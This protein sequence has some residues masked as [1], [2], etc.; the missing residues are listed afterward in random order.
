MP[1]AETLGAAGLASGWML[2]W[3]AAGIIPIAIHLLTRRRGQIVHWGA[4]EL[5]RQVIEREAKR[6]RIEQL[7]LLLLRVA[8]LIMLALAL[9]R[10]FLFSSELGDNNLEDSKPRFWIIALDTSY[11]MSY[12]EAGRTRFDIAKDKALDMVEKAAEGDA[13][14]LFE[15]AEPCRPVIARP[16]FDKQNVLAEIRRMKVLDTGGDFSTCAKQILNT[17]EQAKEWNAI[18]QDKAV[19]LLSDLGRDAW[20][21]CCVEPG[22]RVAS[23]LARLASVQVVSV[24]ATGNIRNVGI[25]RMKSSLNRAA[26]GRPIDVQVE[27][28][29]FGLGRVTRLP[30]QFEVNGQTVESNYVDLEPGAS[31]SIGFS[32]VPK[33]AGIVVA[34]AQ[35]PDD[36]LNVDNRRYHV[37]DVRPK[38]RILFLEDQPGDARLIRTSIAPEQVNALFENQQ[39]MSPI[40]ALA[41]DFSSWDV[42]VLNDI[43]AVSNELVARL[44]QFALGGGA[45]ICTFGPSTSPEFWNGMAESADLLGFEFVA[46]SA[47]NSWGLDPLDY[48]SPIAQPFEGYPD[49]GLLTTPIFRYWQVTPT[50]AAYSIIDLAFTNG[51]PLVVRKSLGQGT[52][53]SILSA[54]DSGL[55]IGS[56]SEP[57]WNAIATWP[58]F[59]PLMQ[60]LVQTALDTDGANYNLVAAQPIQGVTTASRSQSIPISILLPD[61]SESVV[62]AEDAPQAAAGSESKRRWQFTGTKL[63][64]IYSASTE[65]GEVTPYAVNINP[66]QSSLEQIDQR[67]FPEFDQAV[68]R[69][70]VSLSPDEAEPDSSTDEAIRA[71]SNAA[72][73]RSGYIS[74]GLLG[75]LLLLL[76]AESTLGWFIGRRV[77]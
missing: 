4:M 59:V 44:E 75:M 28:E 14:A 1:Y 38:T 50:E 16:T 29:N 72:A 66:N 21:A 32:L 76:I 47:E 39:S 37:I 63:S 56:G 51:D 58:S 15:V 23:E 3:A 46:P 61:G 18:P 26:L 52:V 67:R 8:I 20:E 33:S 6:V 22:A 49:A 74:Q 5:L 64:G 60:Q 73:N 48:R 10:P 7:I 40:D 45:V 12:Q 24:S 53:I 41:L 71:E 70:V 31:A 54:P 62:Y 69:S 36:G 43:A 68:D 57:S 11:S 13:F 34:A 30:V 27:I 35:I 25:R 42:V 2:I 19:V 17:I 9:A 65:D 55:N 77:G